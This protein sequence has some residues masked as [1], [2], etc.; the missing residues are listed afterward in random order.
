M[1]CCWSK[2]GKYCA[3]GSSDGTTIIYN[4][5][6]PLGHSTNSSKSSFSNSSSKSDHSEQVSIPIL[7]PWRILPG[8]KGCVNAVDWHPSEP[9]IATCSTDRSIIIGEVEL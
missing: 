5:S 2:D 3:V 8:H 6:L 1:R 7:G 4:L 9:V